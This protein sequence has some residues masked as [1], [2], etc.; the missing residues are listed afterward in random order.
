[1]ENL[2]QYKKRQM[3]LT[4]EQKKIERVIR[5]EKAKEYLKDESKRELHRYTN[6]KST[7]R[8]FLLKYIKEEDK[9]EFKEILK[10]L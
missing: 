1:M 9:A 8:N 5:R 10:K 2:T 7:A 4:E 3:R 6:K